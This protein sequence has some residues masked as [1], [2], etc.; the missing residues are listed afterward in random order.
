MTLLIHPGFH[1]TATSW[2]QSTVFAEKRLFRSLLDHHEIDE[3]LVRPHDFDFDPE[4]AKARIAALRAGATPGVVDVIS[5]EILSGNIILG[6]RDS[7]VLADRLG[8]ACPSAKVLLTVRAQQ[9]II[10]SIYLQYIKRGGRMTIEDYLSFRPE[11]G[12][13]W[14]DPGTL[15]FDRVAATYAGHFGADNVL[16]LPQELLSRDR[17]QYLRLLCQHVGLAP[18]T[19]EDDLARASASGV[20]PPASGVELLRRSGWLRPTPLNPRAPSIVDALGL[21]T[22]RLAYRWTWGASKADQRMKQA[23]KKHSEARYGRA[24]RQ[25]QRFCPVD[26]A[27][28]GYD[29]AE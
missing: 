17:T 24:N 21:L 20:S 3:L 28:L 27:A 11:P 5:S 1:K 9:P 15:E 22:E 16:V 12:Y 10:K 14:F 7:R 13:F 29:L 23:I 4:M 18:S 25:L 6:S 2:L 8:A 26:L 19:A